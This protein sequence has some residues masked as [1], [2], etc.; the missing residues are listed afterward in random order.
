MHSLKDLPTAPTPR[1]RARRRPA[2]RGPARRRSSPA[3]GSPSASCR[4]A[5][6]SAPARRAGPR[7]CTPSG[8][9]STWSPIR[10][11]VD[12]RLAQG[13]RGRAA[14]PSSWPAPGWPGSGRLDEV[15]EVLD[16]LQMLPAPGQGALA[17]ECRPSRRRRWPPRCATRST[18]RAPAP[19]SP[20]SGACWPRSRPGCTRPGRRAGRDRRGRRRR[21]AVAARGRAVARTGA[22]P[23]AGPAPGSPADAEALGRGSPPRC[24]PTVRRAC[25]EEPAHDADDQPTSTRPHRPARRTTHDREGDCEQR[26]QTSTTTRTT[27]RP[28]QVAFVGSGPG[29]PD[30][31]TRPRGR[32][33][34]RGRRRASPRC[35]TTPSCS[36]R[37]R[38][39]LA[40]RSRVDGVEPTRRRPA[41]ARGRRRRLRQRRPAADPR[42]PRQGRG[43]AGQGRP[44][45]RP[46]DGRRPV[47]LRLRPRGGA[48]CVKAGVAFEIVPGVSS[49]TAVPGL[50]RRPADHQAAP[51]GRGRRPARD[52]KVDWTPYADD[53]TL[54][55]L[56]ARRLDRRRSPRR[57]SRPAAPPETPVAM[58]RVGTTTEQR[59][60][61]LHA[62]ADR[63]RRAGR[64]G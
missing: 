33:A 2:A 31:L 64:R 3:T 38:R 5:P 10:G 25:I 19:R 58:T 41:A 30:L 61:G 17:V 15:T 59:D 45:R 22:S 60:R 34:P 57:W 29:D 52:A 56:S 23:Y 46:A 37:V 54:V 20:P 47:P 44:P 53:R 39:L 49:A 16:P 7:S 24:S 50:R 18:T 32:P 21:G 51:R 63:R 40:P 11:N 13:R 8:S 42:R 62:G 14:T 1:R 6:G 48:A 35:P 43:P 4:P 36:A 55:L 27:H 9:A 26:P 12:T 28:A